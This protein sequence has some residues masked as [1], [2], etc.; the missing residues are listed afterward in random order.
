M[1]GLAVSA[2]CILIFV[3]GF[4]AWQSP[5]QMPKLPKSTTHVE[6]CVF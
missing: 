2:G 4:L 6:M 3:L 5:P 1:F